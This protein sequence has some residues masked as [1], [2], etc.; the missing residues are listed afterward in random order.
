M[1]AAVSFQPGR[2]MVVLLLI[3]LPLLLSLGCWQLQRAEEKRRF[4]VDYLESLS[5]LPT[6]PAAGSDQ[7]PFTRLRLRG[8]YDSERQFLIDNQIRDGQVGYWVVTPFHGEDGRS[9]LVNRGWIAAA[10]RRERLPDI[11]VEAGPQ[12]IVAVVWPDTGLIPALAAEQWSLDWPLRIQRLDV[13]NMAR[14]VDSEPLQL[15]LEAGQPGVLEPAPLLISVTASKHIGY[16]VQ[17]FAFAAVLAVGFL[18]YG[19][20]MP[21]RRARLRGSENV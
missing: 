6:D 20:T 12:Q 16:A 11:S 18:I 14:L 10:E 2:R 8:H 13:L 5:R 9:W 17:W 21:K 1:W 19:F 7:Q 15:R 3:G 4:E